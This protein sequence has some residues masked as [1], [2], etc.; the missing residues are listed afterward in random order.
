VRCLTAMYWAQTPAFKEVLIIRIIICIIETQN[1]F[2]E[3][4]SDLLVAIQVMGSGLISL[5]THDHIL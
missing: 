3:K 5:A 4:I 2:L 1:S